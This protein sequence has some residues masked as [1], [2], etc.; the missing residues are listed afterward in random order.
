M[1]Y[2]DN[3]VYN[4]HSE[5]CRELNMDLLAKN[6]SWQQYSSISNIYTLE[7]SYLIYKILLINQ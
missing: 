6:Y 4:T 5:L 2:N 7:V 1:A 3:T